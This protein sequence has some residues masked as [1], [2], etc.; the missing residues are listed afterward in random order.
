MRLTKVVTAEVTEGQALFS[1]K[2][3]RQ[4]CFV[5]LIKPTKLTPAHPVDS[6]NSW[7]ISSIRSSKKSALSFIYLQHSKAKGT[8]CLAEECNHFFLSVG[9]NAFR[10]SEKLSETFGLRST[11]DFFIPILSYHG[12]DKPFEFMPVLCSDV[13][14]VIM[15]IP[16]S[17]VPAYDKVSVAV[18]KDCLPHILPFIELLLC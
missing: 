7:C 8:F 15:G 9:E 3:L 5:S 18:I 14:K 1:Y 13:R 11:S 4:S 2:S 6:V 12:H 10:A 16:N 17:E